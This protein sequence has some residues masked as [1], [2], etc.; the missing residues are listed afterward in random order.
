MDPHQGFGGI[1]K[2]L[3]REQT[4]SRHIG[5]TLD[6]HSIVTVWMLARGA[7]M[8]CLRIFWRKG[9]ASQMQK[10]GAKLDHNQEIKRRPP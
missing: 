5:V 2:E 1:W 10:S 4:V 8:K 7:A 3:T 6:R 9:L